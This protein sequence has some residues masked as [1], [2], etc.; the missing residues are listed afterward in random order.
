MTAHMIAVNSQK[1]SMS[2][3]PFPAKP[4]KG[5]SHTV[6][7]TLPKSQGPEVLGA[8]S[9]KS[10]RPKSKSNPLRPSESDYKIWCHECGWRVATACAAGVGNV[11]GSGEGDRSGDVGDI[12]GGVG[13][14]GCDV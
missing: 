13:N 4:K 3:L 8:L 7:L 10:K 12:S 9:M 1:D 5:K 2:P 6:T 14:G 11:G